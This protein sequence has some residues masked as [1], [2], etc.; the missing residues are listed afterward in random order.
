MTL[1][2][3]AEHYHRILKARH[4]RAPGLVEK[5]RLRNPGDPESW[6]PQDDDYDGQYT[7]M[8]LAMES[9][10]Y[11]VTRD[12]EA[13][14]GARRAFEAL[15]FLQTVT[16]TSGFVARTVIPADWTRMSDPNQAS[17]ER[18][19][20]AERVR[21]PRDK[22][23][24]NR[25]R[26]SKDGQWRWKGDTSSDEITGHFFGYLFYHDLA[27][28]GE[29]RREAAEHVRKIIDG[30]I[31]D[32]FVLKDID[33]APTRWAV[34]SPE[35]LNRDPDWAN[36]R[37]VN[38][39]EMLSFLKVA[40]HMTG[41]EKY[42]KEYLRLIREHGYAE[43]ALGAK[44]TN[45]SIRT[46][47]DDEL[48]CLAYPGLLRCEKDPRLLE[49]YR[50]SL[51]DWHAAVREEGSPYY[52]FTCASLGGKA[53]RL[54]K[55]LAFLRDAPL[56]LVR[57]TMDNSKREDLRLVHAPELEELQT[58]RLS[59]ASERCTMRWDDN[60]WRAVQGDGGRTESDGDF[61]LLPY[62]MGRYFGFIGPPEE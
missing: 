55:A 27:A 48:L 42:Q 6:E 36:E 19:W 58:D 5:C 16:G 61:W 35:K 54:E 60:P 2:R 10:R 30:I 31:G 40:W 50:R 53:V 13:K 56:D 24:E 17:S 14:A 25:W 41:D 22:R 4:V 15:R 52:D 59:P 45:P 8:C 46:H 44:T 9:F 20:A 23:V 11:A 39:V 38:S 7:A 62:W 18:R 43:N 3:K 34:W 32:G 37:G 49:I 12:P 28:E 47:I 1:A 51:E 21:D 26:L 33:G 57:W 29:E